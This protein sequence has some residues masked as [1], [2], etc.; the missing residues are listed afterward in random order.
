[1]SGGKHLG[2]SCA[3]Q[4]VHRNIK[5]MHLRFFFLQNLLPLKI[6]QFYA[7]INQTMAANRVDY[8]QWQQLRQVSISLPQ[9]S[10]SKLAMCKLA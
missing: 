4:N 1:V 8:I 6:L 10:T 2:S 3:A 9:C 5:A 7:L